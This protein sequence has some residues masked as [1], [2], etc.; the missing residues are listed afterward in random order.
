MVVTGDVR[1]EFSQQE[2]IV[3]LIETDLANPAL[4]SI[5]RI[6]PVTHHRLE[7]QISVRDV[8]EEQIND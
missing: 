6:L 5:H 2:L 1:P 3:Q 8:L 7:V 4:P